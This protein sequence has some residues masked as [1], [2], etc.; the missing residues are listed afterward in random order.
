MGATAAVRLYRLDLTWFF[1][2]QA[3]DVAA[4]AAIARGEALPLLGPRIGWTDAYLGPLYYYVLAVPFLFTANPL[5]GAVFVAASNVAAAIALYRFARRFWGDVAALAAAALFGVFPLAVWSSRLVWHTGLLPLGTVLFMRSLFAVA[6]EGRSVAAI[7]MLGL[8]AVLTQLHLTTVAFAPMALLALAAAGRRLEWRHAVVGAALAVALYTPYLAHEAAHGFENVRALTGAAV[9]DGRTAPEGP[10]ATL[11][12]VLRLYQPVVAGFFPGEPAADGLL[13]VARG[14]HA[15]EAVLFAAGILIAIARL[16][17][18]GPATGSAR[19]ADMLL[20]LWV[21]VPLLVLGTRATPMWWY[22]F[23]L[24][25]PSQFVLAGIAVSTLVAMVPAAA[26]QV[27]AGAALGLVVAVVLCQAALVARVQQRASREG[28]LV[29]DVSRFPVNTAP[30]P[31]GQLAS[32]PL[33]LRHRLVETLRDEFAVGREEFGRRVHGTVLGLAEENDYLLR[34]LP[35]RAAPPP[36]RPADTHYLVTRDSLPS[37]RRGEIRAVQ[38][39]PY[40]V[41]E[42]RP[43]IDYARWEYGTASARTAAGTPL[44]WTAVGSAWPRLET[45]L[46][47][48]DALVLRGPLLVPAAMAPPVIAV[49]VTSWTSPAAIALA[50][51]GVPARPLGRTLRQ[52]PLMIP[53]DS[54]WLMGLGW[55]AEVGFD[56]G[57]SI[58]AG[59]HVLEVRVTGAGPTIRVDVFE[60]ARATRDG[61]PS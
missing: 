14:L 24:L 47:A 12:S 31:F 7:P 46:P 18:R 28:Q 43:M 55:T 21:G 54:R 44:R 27:A 53:R 58:P 36:A 57:E 19:R 51:D 40:R 22:Y 45:D 60:R 13:A 48:G 33:G 3:R 30:S 1:L 23:D 37:S 4:A 49:A 41:A 10:G 8:L 39:G 56:L 42:Y 61:A 5:A 9:A 38:V 34:H 2:D 25:Y 11:A 52:D 17:R 50:V 59:E 6:V 32:L 35:P 20:L 26:R 15:V 16:V 29:L